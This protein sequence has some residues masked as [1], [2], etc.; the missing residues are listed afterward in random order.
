[1]TILT[2]L[3]DLDGVIR[4][5]DPAHLAGV[6]ERHGL[7]PGQLMAA[8]FAPELLQ[9]AITGKITRSEWI[10]QMGA[11]VGSLAAAVE[12]TS[13][14]G[15]VDPAMLT[16]T[17]ELRANGVPVAVLTNGTDNFPGEMIDLGIDDRFD[18]V[19][20]TAHIGFAKPDVRA[21]SFVC[22]ALEV[23]PAT[24]FFTDDSPS[25]L[26]GAIELG[27]QAEVFTDVA[28]LRLSLQDLL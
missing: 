25:K 28:S 14:R 21:F 15:T 26:A 13:N 1:M 3:F 12:W 24:V 8:A 22:D 23:D 16:L 2:V 11:Q 18:A 6:E 20:T 10:E 7:E 19:F 27:M 17:D 4:H 5:F 9:P